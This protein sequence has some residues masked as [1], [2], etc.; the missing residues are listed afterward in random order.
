MYGYNIYIYAKVTYSVHILNLNIQRERERVGRAGWPS[1]HL[2]ATRTSHVLHNAKA[3]VFLR[4]L[5]WKL[6]L[7]FPLCSPLKD[8]KGAT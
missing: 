7:K 3:R 5:H 1:C 4:C 2:Y 8:S 6:F